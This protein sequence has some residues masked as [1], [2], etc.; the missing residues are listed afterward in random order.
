MKEKWKK[1]VI[2]GSILALAVV[3]L[4]S[5][6][7]SIKEQNKESLENT[8]DHVIEKYTTPSSY[9][10]DEVKELLFGEWEIEQLIG[11]TYIQNDYTNYPEGHNV[12]GKKISLMEDKF[13]TQD[14]GNY[15]RYQCLMENPEYWI[16]FTYKNKELDFILLDSLKEDKETKGI[17][18]SEYFQN[19]AVANEKKSY[20]PVVLLLSSNKQLILELDGAYYKMKKSGTPI[21]DIT[22]RLGQPLIFLS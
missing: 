9:L 1:A 15:P 7:L 19:I 20:A 2:G 3:I 21:H 18:E 12:I 5:I 22:S 8:K 6:C 11:F 16:D 17:A 14:L 10:E 4:G 13:S